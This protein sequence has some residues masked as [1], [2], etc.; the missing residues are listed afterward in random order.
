MASNHS[1]NPVEG[2]SLARTRVW[3]LPTR[4]FHWALAVA[5]VGLVITGK[6]GGNALEWHMRLGYLVMALLVFRLFWGF[7]GGRWSRFSSFVYGPST[8]MAYLRGERGPGGRWE[9]GHSPTGALSV[10]AMLGLLVLQVATGLVVDD[11]IATTGPLYRFV[12]S[13]VSARATG[14]HAGVGSWLIISLVV[15]HVAAIVFYTR[16]RKQRLVPAMVTGDKDLAAALEASRDDGPSR[17]KA[18]VVF[19]LGL[20]LAAWISS[21]AM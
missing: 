9:A 3:D 21:L 6:I 15:L 7:V 16:V 17:I 11:E 8:L 4:I 20:A 10:F 14:W 18:L 1:F 5:I 19:G 13:A 2:S 12:S